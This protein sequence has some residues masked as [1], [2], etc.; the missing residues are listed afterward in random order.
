M[1]LDRYG[2]KEDAQRIAQKY[3]DMTVKLFRETGRLWEKTDAETGELSKVEYGSE[4]LMGW[5]AGVFVALVEYL[6][7]H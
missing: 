6:Y 7:S 3:I 2:Y 1:S 5:T 4:P